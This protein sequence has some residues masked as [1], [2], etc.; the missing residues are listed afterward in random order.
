MFSLSRTKMVGEN[1]ETPQEV[2]FFK[3]KDWWLQPQIVEY[4]PDNKIQE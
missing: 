2:H 1:V 3:S 4:G